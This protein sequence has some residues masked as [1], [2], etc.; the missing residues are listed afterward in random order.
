MPET[1]QRTREEIKQRARQIAIRRG[2]RS[3]DPEP[4]AVVPLLPKKL[5]DHPRALHGMLRTGR[6]TGAQATAARAFLAD[7]TAKQ[8]EAALNPTA[9]TPEFPGD[10]A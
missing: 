2:L 9:P 5:T 7:L 1:P 3:S 6:L 8:Q 4:E 10:A